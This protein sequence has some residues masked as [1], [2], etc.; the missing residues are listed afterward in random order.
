MFKTRKIQ[1]DQ[2]EAA[3]KADF[4]QTIKMFA[5]LSYQSMLDAKFD[6]QA[7]RQI[8]AEKINACPNCNPV[9]SNLR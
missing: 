9:F 2:R 7:S 5:S 6:R 1:R 4:G 3:S 8:R